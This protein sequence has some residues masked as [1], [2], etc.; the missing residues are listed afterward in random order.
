MTMPGEEGSCVGPVLSVIV[1]NYNNEKY[2]RDCLDSILKQ[3]YKDLEIIVCDD[4]SSDG[5]L[6]ILNEY[7]KYK[8]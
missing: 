6:G 2:I 5:S 4:C 7:K 1:A 8:K 3:T